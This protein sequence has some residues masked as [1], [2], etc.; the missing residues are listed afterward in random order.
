MGVKLK[1]LVRS[2]EVD[3]EDLAGKTIAVDAF[4]AMYQ[5]LAKIR[6]P[7]GTPLMTSWGEITSVHS[8]VFYRTANLL[9]KGIIPVYVFDGEKPEF[10]M[11]TVMER[12]K[13]R[14]EAERKWLESLEA[15]DLEEARKYAQA[16]L[17]LTDEMVEDA[18]KI[19]ELMGVPVVQ[20]PSEGEAQ[21]A[22]MCKRGDVW[23]VGSQDYDSL[24]FGSPRLVRNLTITGKRKLPGKPVYV[25]VRPE[26]IE[27]NQV[28]KELGITREQLVVLGILVGTDYNPGG[29]KGI[30]PKRALEIVKKYR[31]DPLKVFSR[32]EWEFNIDPVRIFEFFMSPPVTEEYSVKLKKPKSDELIDFMVRGH[33]FSRSRVEKVVKQVEEAYKRLSA[34]SLEA[35][36]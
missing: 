10:K 29:V 19:L 23:A 2:K 20:A 27:L 8:G 16:A 34:G 35:W 36:F 22:Y 6:Q 7:D 14:E 12:L 17:N 13:V 26:I 32:V 24:M 5:F 18:K 9:E 33:E 3:L 31:D 15:G 28:L 21:A 4:N 25:E 1:E 11:E 30:G